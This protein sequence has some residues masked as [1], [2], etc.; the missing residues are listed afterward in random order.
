ML[1]EV[2]GGTAC[3]VGDVGCNVPPGLNGVFH[4]GQ[5]IIINKKGDL[6]QFPTVFDGLWFTIVTLTTTGMIFFISFLNFLLT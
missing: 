6:S 2:E 5:R 1:F 4:D 3:Y